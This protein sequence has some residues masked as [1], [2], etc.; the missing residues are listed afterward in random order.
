MRLGPKAG[1][2]FWAMRGFSGPCLFPG[3]PF[4]S[5]LGPWPCLPAQGC[6]LCCGRAW[7]PTG[8][9]KSAPLMP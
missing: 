6:A 5:D 8:E 7:Q 9:P 1:G 3:A 2:M 4:M